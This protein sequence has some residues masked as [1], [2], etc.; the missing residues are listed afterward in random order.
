MPVTLTNEPLDFTAPLGFAVSRSVRAPAANA[1][2]TEGTAF[3]A[4]TATGSTH[5]YTIDL[6]TGAATDLGTISAGTQPLAGLAIGQT[7]VH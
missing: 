3:A 6:T 1:P 5:L 2:V 4:L 7:A